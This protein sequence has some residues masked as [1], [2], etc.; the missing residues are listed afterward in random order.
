M[1]EGGDENMET[2]VSTEAS[3]DLYES[4]I[5]TTEPEVDI[6]D[7]DED[8]SLDIAETAASIENEALLPIEDEIASSIEMEASRTDYAETANL[9]D[10]EATNSAMEVVDVNTNVH[11]SDI[12]PASP[13]RYFVVKAQTPT[14]VI[15]AFEEQKWVTTEAVGVILTA[16]LTVSSVTVIVMIQSAR[17]FLGYAELA[18]P[19]KL[20]EETMTEEIE[21]AVVT[22]T[23]SSFELSWKKFCCLS[24]DNSEEVL[25][26]FDGN[27]RVNA[28]Q[29]GQEV[30][31]EAAERLIS[32][33]GSCEEES[34]DTLTIKLEK[35]KVRKERTGSMDEPMK[36]RKGMFAY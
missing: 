35:A 27:R 7:I 14:E 22:T 8:N 12:A 26:A 1:S 25:N 4:L 18:L 16:A 23:S 31:H 2:E 36:Q 28:A 9:V 19:I 17:H 6:H 11:D 20:D 3:M 21:K 30:S 29:D 15:Q 10:A 34:I 13:T 5:T 33:L 32:L 24:F